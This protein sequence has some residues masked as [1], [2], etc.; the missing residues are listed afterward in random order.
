MEHLIQPN[1]TLM[2]IV[3][4]YGHRDLAVFNE[5]IRLNDNVYSADLL[6]AAGT[7]N[8]NPY[9]TLTPTVERTGEDGEKSCNHSD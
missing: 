5:V 4:L 6:P 3:Q 1:Q 9:P 2:E 8:S 7:H